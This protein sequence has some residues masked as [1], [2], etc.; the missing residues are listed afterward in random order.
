MKR[1]AGL[2]LLILAIAGI[3]N[4]FRTVASGEAAPASA[5]AAYDAGKKTGRYTA[6]FVFV[7]LGL[8]GAHWLFQS[9]DE[10]PAPLVRRSP[11]YGIIKQAAWQNF[12]PEVINCV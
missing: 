3:V 11:I 1:I 4:V 8:L 6:P 9:E 12:S 2:L 10:R 7:A 5:S